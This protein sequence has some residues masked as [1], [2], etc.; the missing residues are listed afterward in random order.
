MVISL[1][2]EWSHIEANSHKKIDFIED[3]CHLVLAVNGLPNFLEL[4]KLVS[5]I[6]CDSE[7]KPCEGLLFILREIPSAPDRRQLLL[8]VYIRKID[9]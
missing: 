2:Q 6:H 4:L 1:D 9:M 3:L 5:K 8:Q 7:I